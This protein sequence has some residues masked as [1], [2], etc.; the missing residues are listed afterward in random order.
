MVDFWLSLAAAEAIQRVAEAVEKVGNVGYIPHLRSILCL[1][2]SP[3]CY[4]SLS[5][6]ATPTSLFSSFTLW[7]RLTPHEALLSLGD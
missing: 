7:L 5:L 2:L 1:C 4:V 3:R 6:S